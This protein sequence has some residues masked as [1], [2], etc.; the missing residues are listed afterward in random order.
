MK[1]A[2][3][4]SGGKD[5]ILALQ[6]C[7][8]K[9][10]EVRYLVSFFSEK[11]E[12]YMYN[13]PNMSLAIMQSLSLGFKLVTKKLGPGKEQEEMKSALESISKDIEGVLVG[14][15]LS[16]KQKAFL[17]QICKSLG[18]KLF[19][20]LAGKRQDAL[21]KKAL[22]SGFEI[23]IVYSKGMD[24][25]WLGRT[26]QKKDLKSISGKASAFRT[27]VINGPIF[28]SRMAI[29]D[30]AKEW[31]GKEGRFVIKDAKLKGAEAPGEGAG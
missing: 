24:R 3:L 5:S 23:V 9:G 2:V 25:K 28:R 11:P 19:T 15:P 4:F 10:F 7:L 21:W 16:K 27:L 29:T 26:V 12:P 13:H 1:V 20:P 22:D 31:E 18:V 14:V 8:R 6:D 17:S 30:S